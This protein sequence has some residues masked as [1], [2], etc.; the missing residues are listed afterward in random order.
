MTA[1][2]IQDLL[3]VS[4]GQHLNSVPANNGNISMNAHWHVNLA[5]EQH[6]QYF[7]VDSC[8]CPLPCSTT[9]G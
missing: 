6:M 8:D 2:T 3:M 5:K 1:Q 7:P 9:R 4:N